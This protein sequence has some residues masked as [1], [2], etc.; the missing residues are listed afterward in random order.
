MRLAVLTIA[1]SALLA[2]VVAVTLGTTLGSDAYSYL[3]WA[4]EAV[5]HGETGHS[6]YDATVPKPLELA[7]ATLGQLVG[8]PLGT[9]AVWNALSIIGCALAAGVLA[10]RH[11]G[12]RAGA[13][14]AVV[15]LTIPVVWRG[16]LAGDSNVPYA[17]LVVAAAAAG[18]ATR[19]ASGLLAL[20]GLLRPEA[21]GLAAVSAALGWRDADR[22]ERALALAATVIPPALWLTLDRIFTGDWLYSFDVLSRYVERYTPPRVDT[23][24]VTRFDELYGVGLA[25]GLL[26]LIVLARSLPLDTAVVF[27]AAL[28]CAVA[29]EVAL[30]DVTRDSFGRMLTALA[31][32]AAVGVGLLAARLGKAGAL[33]AAA[34]LVLAAPP[35]LDVFR[36][37]HAQGERADDLRGSVGEAA[38]RALAGGGLAVT[39]RAYQGA[40]ALHTGLRRA[41]VVPSSAVGREVAAEDVAAILVRRGAPAPAAAAG[42]SRAARGERFDLYVRAR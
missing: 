38:T 4:R 10:A 40:L 17:A 15:T 42:G 28:V 18:P 13:V 14:A 24:V 16:G 9:F 19:G 21:W 8:A 33:L 12:R 29:I 27:P 37:G 5:E 41:R 20:A 26:G 34:C 30:G 3:V 35:L 32:F 6:P 31:V 25:L 11:A 7:W 36:E 2:V 39:G 23:G 22:G 1:A